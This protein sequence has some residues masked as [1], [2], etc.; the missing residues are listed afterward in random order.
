MGWKRWPLVPWDMLDMSSTSAANGVVR[1]SRVVCGLQVYNPLQYSC[2]ENSMDRGA[3]QAMVQVVK[4]W[5]RLKIRTWL[6]NL[7]RLKSLTQLSD[8]AHTPLRERLIAGQGGMIRK[9]RG[10]TGRIHFSEGGW[11]VFR[12]NKSL[13]LQQAHRNSWPLALGSQSPSPA[14]VDCR[15]LL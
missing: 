13:S 14:P 4:S 11:M 3:W 8:Q 2:L 7:M 5:T 15:V 9:R 6:K 10:F 1:L 12:L